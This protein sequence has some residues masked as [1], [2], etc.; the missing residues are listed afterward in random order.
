ML[1]LYSLYFMCHKG[2]YRNAHE[3]FYGIRINMYFCIKQITDDR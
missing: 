3:S 1:Y 2:Y